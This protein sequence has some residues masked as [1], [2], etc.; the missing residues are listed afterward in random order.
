MYRLEHG[1]EYPGRG[2]AVINAGKGS[3][4]A[5]SLGL[6][7]ELLLNMGVFVFILGRG[8][9]KTLTHGTAPSQCCISHQSE[10]LLR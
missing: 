9:K 2:I 3:D 1:L 8:L 7:R 5:D 6:A 4:R 10:C